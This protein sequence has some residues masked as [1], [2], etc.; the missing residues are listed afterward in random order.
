MLTFVVC[1]SLETR[2]YVVIIIFVGEKQSDET[3]DMRHIFS[4]RK[5][6]T[7]NIQ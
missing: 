1:H 4:D 5:F 2:Y 6:Q 7:Q 3:R